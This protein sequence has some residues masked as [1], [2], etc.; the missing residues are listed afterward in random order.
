LTADNLLPPIQRAETN[1]IDL[2]NNRERFQHQGGTMRGINK[3]IILGRLGHDINLKQ[4][5]KGL[6]FVDLFV[7]TNRSI[8][9]EKDWSSVADWHRIR[10]WGKDA[11]RCA[12]FLSKGSPIAVEGS[13]RTDIWE[14]KE[15]EKKYSGF[16][17]GEKLHFLPNPQLKASIA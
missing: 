16:I 8:Q 6:A 1:G 3:V 2:A 5:N 9:K 17:H 14:T 12:K 10:F 15:G 4:T 11:E 13:L 7:A